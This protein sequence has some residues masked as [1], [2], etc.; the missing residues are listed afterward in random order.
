VPVGSSAGTPAMLSC[1]LQDGAV[2]EL[3]SCFCSCNE[4]N[5]DGSCAEWSVRDE[6]PL[7]VDCAS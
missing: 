4:V 6:S 2:P 3:N 7:V 5:E 1:L